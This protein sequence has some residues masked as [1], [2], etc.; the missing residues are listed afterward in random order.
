MG[1][2]TQY[3]SNTERLKSSVQ[4]SY[5]RMGSVQ[6]HQASRWC[7]S[8]ALD[9]GCRFRK[10]TPLSPHPWAIA[11]GAPLNFSPL[12]LKGDFHGTRCQREVA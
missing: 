10:Q 4:N 11:W 7:E 2:Q 5:E 8:G 6:N 3:K 9:W 12:F 1:S